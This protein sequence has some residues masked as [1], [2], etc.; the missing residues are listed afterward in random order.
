MKKIPNNKLEKGNYRK[1]DQEFRGTLAK[2]SK[3]KFSLS[4]VRLKK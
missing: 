3:A 4:E 2:N 1:D